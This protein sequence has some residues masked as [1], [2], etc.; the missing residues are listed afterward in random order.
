MFAKRN[1]PVRVAVTGGGAL[2]GQ[3]MIRAL[4]H[5]KLETQIIVAD[6]SPMSAGLYWGDEAFLVPPAKSDDYV[7]AISRLIEK[8]NPDIILVG[9][10]VELAPLAEARALLESKYNT[11]VLVSSPEVVA[12]ADNKFKTAQFF[13]DNGIPAPL[14]ALATDIDG[15]ESLI[16]GH[17][18]PLVVKPCIGARSYG[19]NIVYNLSELKDAISRV[20][21]AVIQECI[22]TDQEEY[23]ASGLYFDGKCDAVIVMRRDLRDGNTYRAY[24][25]KD[26]ALESQ[27]KRW[28]E[29]LK[30][31]GPANFQFRLDKF[32]VAKV[33]E[34]NGRFSG[35]TPLRA[36]AGFNEV[37]ICIRKILWGEPI[38][39]PDIIPITVLRHWSET[40]IRADQILQVTHI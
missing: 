2:L 7:D 4:K 5:S 32:G 25:V 38:S 29:L 12:I 21:N 40:V 33:F 14:S 27:V 13:A 3:G 10:D 11:R 8:S 36:Y 19:V 15:I 22:G 31:F 35:T 18:F 6:V 39:Q 24:V 30:P 34:I 23:T 20:E 37:E 16:A 28:T 9:T 26:I 1:Q 17:G